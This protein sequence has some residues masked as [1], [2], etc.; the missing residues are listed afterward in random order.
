M[1]RG[2]NY[3]TIITVFALG[4]LLDFPGS[5]NT[6]I[7]GNLSSILEYG[8][9]NDSTILI[10]NSN[11]YVALK[12]YKKGCKLP[13]NCHGLCPTRLVRFPG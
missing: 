5:S 10:F 3:L 9:G 6:R 12:I 2:V 11:T 8:N 4:G 1:E 7:A 13:I